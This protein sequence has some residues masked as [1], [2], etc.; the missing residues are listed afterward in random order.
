MVIDPERSSAQ[1]GSAVVKIM[2][3]TVKS[4][5]FSIHR[6]SDQSVVVEPIAGSIERTIVLH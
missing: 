4:I 2:V 3:S 6:P 5:L 1:V